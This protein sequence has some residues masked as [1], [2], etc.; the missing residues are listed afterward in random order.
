VPVTPREYEYVFEVADREERLPGAHI[1]YL[2]RDFFAAANGEREQDDTMTQPLLPTDPTEGVR[3]GRTSLDA[4]AVY[5]PRDDLPPQTAIG[6][7]GGSN[8]NLPAPRSANIIDP[9]P[10]PGTE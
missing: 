1:R 6:Q 2:L 5:A 10:F 7:V 4:A 9:H 8:A 3:P